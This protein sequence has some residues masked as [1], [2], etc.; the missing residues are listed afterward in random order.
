MKSLRDLLKKQVVQKKVVFDDKDVFYIFQKVIKE[1]F[2]NVGASK[3]TVR[4]FGNKT[5]FVETESSNW[6]SELW[7]NKKKIVE[8][9]NQQIGE[10]AV[11]EIRVNG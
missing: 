2:G 9:M 8:K 5:V 10:G 11:R 7:L 1:E 4:Y 6:A 3:F